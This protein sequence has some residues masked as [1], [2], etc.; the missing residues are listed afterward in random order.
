MLSPSILTSVPFCGRLHD[1]GS[2]HHPF[3]MLRPF[4]SLVL[5]QLDLFRY[6]QGTTAYENEVYL[7]AEAVRCGGDELQILHSV[8]SPTVFIRRQ[9]VS[10]G[11]KLEKLFQGGHG[12]CGHW[13]ILGFKVYRLFE[14]GDY[15]CTMK[16]YLFPLS[17]SLVHDKDE[18]LKVTRN[19]QMETSTFS[20]PT[21]PL[22]RWVVPLVFQNPRRFLYR[23]SLK[24]GQ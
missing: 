15:R 10:G 19:P 18:I 21:L 9:T 6:W 7:F 5:M 8:W 2:G 22:S 3:L 13:Q 11:V 1:L 14:G 16:A 20:E 12:C 24:F 17:T 4:T 23:V